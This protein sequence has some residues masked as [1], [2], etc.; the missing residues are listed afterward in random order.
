M[1]E[2]QGKYHPINAFFFDLKLQSIKGGFDT[3]D[4]KKSHSQ[5]RMAFH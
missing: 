1:S 3:V 2:F 5:L 4:N